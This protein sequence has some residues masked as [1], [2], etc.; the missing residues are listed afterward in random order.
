M[1]CSGILRSP[2]TKGAPVPDH[3]TKN[4]ASMR[5]GG[6]THRAIAFCVLL[7]LVTT[8]LLC[9]VFNWQAYQESIQ[10]RID[11]GIVDARAL[12]QNAEPAV[13]LHDD[14]GLRRI[15]ESATQDESIVH[16]QVFDVSR[17]V[18]AEDRPD[19]DRIEHD[20]PIE[21]PELDRVTRDWYDVQPLAGGVRV[22]VPI[23][24]RVGEIDLG[25][26]VD[27]QSEP[28]DQVLGFLCLEYSFHSQWR[29]FVA[30]MVSTGLAALIVL[31]AA[32]LT[33]AYTV[34]KFLEPVHELVD[35][36]AALAGGDLDRRAR[37]DVP[38]ELG[39]LAESL[40]Y[41]ANQLQASYSRLKGSYVWVE[42][43]V[44][45]RTAELAVQRK[46][47]LQTRADFFEVDATS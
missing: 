43:Q 29:M 13:L 11:D 10:A 28:T 7:V 20:T 37:E 26:A 17:R 12:S 32:T 33:T 4:F 41:M 24:P 36:T 44:E 6:L 27:G 40:N 19:R 31:I 8:A 34:R 23:R 46:V 47:T 38:G 39:L 9:G 42:R 22:L 18:L 14:K 30:R 2:I 5:T 16:T 3:R 45:I 25:L 15:V 35:I 1:R 21:F